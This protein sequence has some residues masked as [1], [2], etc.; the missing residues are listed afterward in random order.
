MEGIDAALGLRAALRQHRLDPSR[1]VAGD[2]LQAL[3][4]LGAERVEERLDRRLVAPRRRPDQPPGVVVDD[5][6]QVAVALAVGD[7][8]DPDPPQAGEQVEVTPRLYGHPLADPADAAPADPHQL[9]DGAARRVHRQPGDLLLEGSREARVVPGPGD[10]ADDHAM[11]RAAHSR[12]IGLQVGDRRAEVQRPPASPPLAEVE[13]RGSAAADAAA[14]TL[15]MV[16]ADRHHY[17]PPIVELH[18]L[19]HCSL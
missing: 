19:D 8:V 11:L 4:A 14:V 17:L 10:G 1:H 18:A 9:R 16:R 13:A 3:G 6:G 7:L 15:P 12:R 5:H 2:E